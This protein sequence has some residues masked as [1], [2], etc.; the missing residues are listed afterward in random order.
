MLVGVKETD[1]S[2][3]LTFLRQQTAGLQLQHCCCFFGIDRATVKASPLPGEL[4]DTDSKWANGISP[5]IGM[6]RNGFF[7]LPGEDSL[8]KQKRCPPADTKGGK[9]ARHEKCKTLL[10]LMINALQPVPRRGD[11]RPCCDRCVWGFVQILFI[12]LSGLIT[13]GRK[14]AAFNVMDRNLMMTVNF[15]LSLT[16]PIAI[17]KQKLSPVNPRRTTV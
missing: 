11:Q 8:G 9:K 14:L 16:L 12:A 10:S 1:C 5:S 3:F 6:Y 2:V 17:Y 7:A 13:S 15:F 4:V